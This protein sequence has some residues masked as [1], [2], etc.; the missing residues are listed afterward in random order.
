MQEKRHYPSP[1]GKSAREVIREITFSTDPADFHYIDVNIPCQA[2]CPAQ[3]NIPG[4]IR[5]LFE[6]RYD[7]SYELN[8]IVNVLPGVLGRICSRPCEDMCRHGEDELGDPVNICHIKRAAS[9]YKEESHVY[10]EQLLAPLGKKVCI[11]GAGPAGLAAAHD[12]AAIGFEVELIEAFDEPGGMLLYGIPEFRLPRD[13]LRKEIDSILRLGVDLRTGIRV[14]QDVTL[15]EL[16]ERSDAVLVAAGCYIANELGVEGEELPGVI[17]GLDFCIE[18]NQGATPRIG[19]RVLVLGAGFTAFDCA[20]FALRLGAEQV[21]ICL[22]RTEQDLQVTKGEVEEAKFEGANIR[23]LMVTRRVLG[24]EKVEGVEFLRARPGGMRPDGR[25]SIEP[26]EG[27]EFVVPADTVIVAIGQETEPIGGPGSKDEKGVL[28]AD[29]NTYRTSEPKLYAAGDF[30][31]GPT[32]VIDAIARGRAAA[33]VIAED[34]TGKK[35]REWA[36]RIE[37]SQITD[38]EREWDF[39]PF[40]PMPTVEPAAARLDPPAREVES[41]FSPEMAHE[42]AKRC[43]LC[44][45]HYEIDIDRCIYCLYCID[46]APRDC[47]RMVTE[48]VTNEIGAITEYVETEDWRDVRAIVIDNARCIRCGACVRVCPVDCISVSKVEK[49]ERILP[50]EIR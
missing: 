32:T 10:M 38:R 12:L 22:R 50:R 26:I 9:D 6:K 31:T 3:T 34:L 47:I 2:A 24:E 37:E 20:R 21:D 7:R 44:Y 17:P 5:T 14:G 36:V 18:V 41:G 28:S 48:L 11:V 35:F 8:R 45:L 46:V 40:H 23:G 25:Q 13:I 15:E 49:V 30:V 1:D 19:K 27:S 42:E 4:Y 16:L 39:I 29:A 43:Y 33:E